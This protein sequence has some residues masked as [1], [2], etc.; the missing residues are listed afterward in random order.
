MRSFISHSTDFYRQ[1]VYFCSTSVHTKYISPISPPS[2]HLLTKYPDLTSE[3][4]TE[5]IIR[6]PNNME[7]HVQHNHHGKFTSLQIL[8]RVLQF[9]YLLLHLTTV[10]Y[11]CLMLMEIKI[12]Q[13]VFVKLSAKL[14]MK[15]CL[16][17]L[18][19]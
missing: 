13:Q 8:L 19:L 17:I 1:N 9:T 2:Q 6:I 3:K 4:G 11:N 15:T 12:A 18:E 5:Q 7:M 10:H 16:A 14:F